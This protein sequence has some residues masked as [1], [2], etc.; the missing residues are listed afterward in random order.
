MNNKLNT[1]IGYEMRTQRLIRRL[2]LTEVAKRL[3]KAKNTV[4]YWE[5]GKTMIT[6]E[7]LKSYCDA[8][9]CN[10]IEVLENV[11]KKDTPTE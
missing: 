5:L 2:T 11:N 3:D 4:S 6:V 7:D 1:Q 10:W 8:V 9:G